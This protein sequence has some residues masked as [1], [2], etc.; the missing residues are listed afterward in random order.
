MIILIII[1]ITII[2]IIIIVLMGRSWSTRSKKGKHASGL[3][4]A[5]YKTNDVVVK[6]GDADSIYLPM[7]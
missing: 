6:Q 3:E 7:F 1:I 2:M 4:N 5:T